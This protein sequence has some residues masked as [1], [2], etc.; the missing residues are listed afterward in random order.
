MEQISPKLYLN[1]LINQ[2]YKEVFSSAYRIKGKAEGKTCAF[3]ILKG[4]T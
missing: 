3:A 4:Y 1:K 2:G